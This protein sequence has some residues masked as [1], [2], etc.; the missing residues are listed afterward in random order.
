MNIGIIG[1]GSYLPDNR[2]TNI[3]LE[4]RMDTSDEWIRTRT[5]I[6]ARHLADVD[7][8]VADM[9][10][11]AA[12]RALQSAGISIEE[13]DA[14]VCA[15]ATAP[16]FPATACLVQAN[17]GAKQAVA[18]DV[19]AA[20]SGFIFAMDT[21]KSLMQSKGFKKTLVI[22]AEKMGSLIDWEDRSTAVLFGDGAGAVVLGEDAVAS[23]DSIV[24]G[25]DGTGGKHLYESED[26][27]I[28]MNGRE[29]FKFAVRKMPEIVLDALDKAGK[30]LKDLD[31]LVPHQ[32]NRRIID[33]AMERLNLAEE[34][35]VMTIQDHANTS[36]ASIPLA[37]AEAVKA[38]TIRDGQ[39][40]V[41]A[42]FGAGLT[43]GASCLTWNNATIT[44]EINT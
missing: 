8:S 14:I 29:V 34:K 26:G 11:A 2:V 15:T 10:T 21:A 27:K 4:K 25:S 32:A 19:S 22:G 13:I 23:V 18:F 36:A 20:C 37:L 31:V 39:T 38:K 33:A 24:L 42:G 16:S 9:A 43:W 44:E 1:I 7:V 17:L 41:I 12:R 3:D 30:S 35:V 28:V 6:E 5:G 40:V